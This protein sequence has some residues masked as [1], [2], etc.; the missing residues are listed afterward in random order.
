MA[1]IGQINRLQVLRSTDFGLI[2][3]GGSLGDILLPKR[4]VSKEWHLD[5][6]IEV[7]VMIDSED[8]LTATTLRPVAMVGEFACLRVASATR[9]GA[10]L[11]WGLPKDLFVPFREQKVEMREGQSYVVRIYL[12]ETSGRIAAS[13]K[14]DKFLD[15]TPSN[16]KT[17]DKVRLLVCDKT[18]LGF[19][20]IING[21]HWG[22]LFYNEVFQPL[23]RGQKLDGFIKQVRGD[24]KI[25]LCLQKPGFEKVTELTDVILN[26]IKAQGGFMPVTDKSPP[27]EIYRLFG[28]SKKTYKQAIGALYKKRLITFEEKGTRLA[29]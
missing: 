28:V 23:E 12:D 1:T 11:D 17:G 29:K 10:F 20:A 16:Y 25:D 18:D 7:F 24:G 26:Y 5:D 13:A 2:L 14:L 9:I 15:R 6:I 21:R 3:D 27:E 22:I 19:K 8:R 4:Y